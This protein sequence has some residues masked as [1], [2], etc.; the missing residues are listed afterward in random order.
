MLCGVMFQAHLSQPS[1]SFCLHR[2]VCTLPM[3]APLFCLAS[4]KL[5]V[6]QPTI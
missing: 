6:R 5:L 4:L 3:M 1:E 2:Y